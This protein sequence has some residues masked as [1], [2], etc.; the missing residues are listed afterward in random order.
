MALHVTAPN[1]TEIHFAV[2]DSAFLAGAAAARTTKT[3]VVGFIGGYQSLPSESARTGFEQGVVFEDPDVTVM[4]M[5]MGPVDNPGVKARTQ[6]D[7]AAELAMAMYTDGADII[8]HDAGESGL[9][10]VQAAR[11]LSDP[12]HLWVIGSNTDAY[13]TTSSEIDRSHVLTSTIKRYDA[14]VVEAVDAFL[15]DSLASGDIVLGLQEDGVGL[16]DA[17][18]QSHRDRRISQES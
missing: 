5:Y 18:G 17:G 12:S 8:F 10:V 6:P 16:S 2:E 4:S 13:H 7:L 3:G 14:A 15:R 1:I 9:G 11:D